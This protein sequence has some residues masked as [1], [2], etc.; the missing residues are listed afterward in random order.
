MNKR[1]ITNSSAIDTAIC[2]NCGMI[3]HSIPTLDFTGVSMLKMLSITSHC[4]DKPFYW[5]S[6]FYYGHVKK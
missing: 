4:C 6:S 1:D 3:K 5:W 2:E